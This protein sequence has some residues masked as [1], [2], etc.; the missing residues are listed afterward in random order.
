[1][2]EDWLLKHFAFALALVLFII[3]YI[4]VSLYFEG[5]R[6][7]K[8][9]IDLIETINFEDYGRAFEKYN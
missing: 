5:T 8:V 7:R 1:M 6:Q 9:Q 4:T 2:K 3:L